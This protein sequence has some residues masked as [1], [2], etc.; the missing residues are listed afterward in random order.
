MG[1]EWVLARSPERGEKIGD[2]YLMKSPDWDIEDTP[3]ITV[4]YDFD[5]DSVTVYAVRDATDDK[6]DDQA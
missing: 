3:Q 4:L 1:V 6:P 2:Y 5:E